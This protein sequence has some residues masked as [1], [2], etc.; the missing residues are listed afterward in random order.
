MSSVKTQ[1]KLK[2]HVLCSGLRYGNGEEILYEHFKK[3]WLQNPT[4]LEYI[5]KGENLIPTIH[6]ADLA[7]LTKR[8][9]TTNVTKNYIFAI[10]RTIKPTQKRIIQA[11]SNG[12][13][14][15]QTESKDDE[16]FQGELK[17]YLSINLKM[18]CSDAFKDGEPPEDV[19]DAEEEAK[20][21]KFP[22]HC[23]KGIIDNS[24]QLNKEFNSL[25]GL[26]PVKIFI[27]GPP[28]SGK[29]FYA[30]KL[31]TYYNIPIV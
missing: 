30:N 12:I 28:A 2:V 4:A 18:K 26:N 7:R 25:R 14:T 17:E 24:L 19:E 1:P 6:Y 10:D 8:V 31:S 29:T 16:Y 21:L 20:K 11:V 15:G 3:A 5:G 9:C 23:E 13:G 22:W 27:T